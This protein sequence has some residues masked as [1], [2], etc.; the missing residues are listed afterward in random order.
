[1]SF[2]YRS[3]VKVAIAS[4]VIFAVLSNLLFL[5]KGATSFK[6]G[7]EETLYWK[8]FHE[9]KKALPSDARI[10]YV[11]DKHIRT[12]FIKDG[13]VKMFANKEKSVPLD[14]IS[15]KDKQAIVQY[16]LTNNLLAPFSISPTTDR[17]Y[18]VGNF[19][20]PSIDYRSHI[21]DSFILIGDF[22]NG[23]MLF[24]ESAE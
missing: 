8:Q 10:G 1:M 18:L 21:E 9:L 22:G 3:C 17:E 23:L 20:D 6:D 12:V 11:S 13:R 4:I 14:A 15:K 5:L 19:S 24:E 2:D 7:T 16:W